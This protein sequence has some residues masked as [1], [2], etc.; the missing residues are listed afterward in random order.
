MFEDLRSG[1]ATFSDYN[2][3][4]IDLILEAGSMTGLSPAGWQ[5][6]FG[7]YTAKLAGATNTTGMDPLAA[8]G[9]PAL[10]VSLHSPL[11]STAQSALRLPPLLRYC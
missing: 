7:L 6:V 1:R 2:P 8:L 9:F 5:F 4:L 10:I 3:N 11:E